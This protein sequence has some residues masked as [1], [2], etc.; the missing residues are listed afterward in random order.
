MVT[1]VALTTER[2]GVTATSSGPDI[3]PGRVTG[4][5]VTIGTLIKASNKLAHPRALGY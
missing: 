4:T 5:E 2:T 3:Q 1:T